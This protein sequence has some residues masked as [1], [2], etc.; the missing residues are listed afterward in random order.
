MAAAVHS[1]YLGAEV[2]LFA[3]PILYFSWGTA[4]ALL[5]KLVSSPSPKSRAA[6]PFAL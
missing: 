2:D 3:S 4:T 5:F 1:S 6:A